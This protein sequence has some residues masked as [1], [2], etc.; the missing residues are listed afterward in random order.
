MGTLT[1]SVVRVNDP[2]QSRPPLPKE[3]SPALYRQAKNGPD[4]LPIREP[5]NFV[6]DAIILANKP[7]LLSPRNS[8]NNQG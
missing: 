8:W 5:F 6:P 4:P 1:P 3:P 2:A 7:F